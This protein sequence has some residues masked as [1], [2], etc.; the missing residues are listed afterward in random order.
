M[1][2]HRNRMFF[3]VMALAT[4]LALVSCG[5]FFSTTW[6]EDFA[7]NPSGVKVS[8]SNVKDLL[9]DANGDTKASRAILEKL[10]GTKN[11]ALQAAAVKAANQASGLTQLVLSNLDTLTEDTNDTKALEKLGQTVLDEA[12]N[13]DIVGVA[14][15]I[16]ETLPVKTGTNGPEFDGPF[17]KSVPTSDLTILL[18]T[19][20]MAE[21]VDANDDFEEFVEGWGP[22][23]KDINDSSTLKDNEKVIAAIANEVM[24][25]PDSDLGKM[26]KELV[27]K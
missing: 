23:K 19:M 9:R 25:R 3:G 24:T 7:R 16:A 5:D 22:G 13:N 8:E 26:L 6:G 1:K 2:N 11:P 4:S 14:K 27:G 21:A 15:D 20:M 17:V 10:R 18:V 12:K